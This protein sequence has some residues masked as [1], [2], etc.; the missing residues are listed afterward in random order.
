MY[1]T[2]RSFEEWYTFRAIPTPYLINKKSLDY[3]EGFSIIELKRYQLIEYKLQA[4]N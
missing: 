3:L 2:P 4:F 1:P